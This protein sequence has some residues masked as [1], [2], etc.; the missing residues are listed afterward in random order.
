MEAQLNE[1]KSF[2]SDNFMVISV[3]KMNI[4]KF[5]FQNKGLSLNYTLRVLRN[6]CMS[7]VGLNCSGSSNMDYI[8]KKAYG[9]MWTPR[10]MKALDT[11]PLFIQ[12]VAVYINLSE[13]VTR[14]CDC[15]YNGASDSLHCTLFY[16]E[17]AEFKY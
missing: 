14:L 15:S 11:K 17:G 16:K 1:I 3:K 10:R 6:T 2:A 9:K 4:M 8:C 7:S 12:R 5:N 13:F